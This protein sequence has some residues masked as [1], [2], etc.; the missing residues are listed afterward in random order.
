MAKIVG[1][2]IEDKIYTANQA[3]ADG[4]FFLTTIGQV[5]EEDGDSKETWSV[6]IDA[7]L[8]RAVRKQFSA[9]CVTFEQACHVA[10]QHSVAYDKFKSQRRV[11]LKEA[12]KA[13]LKP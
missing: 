7:D 8:A 5:K 3:N 1:Q 10:L 6:R 12:R 13:G 4:L 9:S 2:G 11:G